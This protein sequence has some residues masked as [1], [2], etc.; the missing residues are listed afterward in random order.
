MDDTG[1]SIKEINDLVNEKT[2]KLKGLISKV[3]ALF[4]IAKELAVDIQFQEEL[5]YQDP[6]LSIFN[7]IIK[8]TG[9][10][11]KEINGLVKEEIDELEAFF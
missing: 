1:L 7:K 8:D 11:R 9:L 3:G 10:T 4:I 5:D 6:Y 2:N